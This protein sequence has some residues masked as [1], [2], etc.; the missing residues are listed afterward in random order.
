MLGITYVDMIITV[1]VLCSTEVVDSVGVLVISTVVESSAEMLVVVSTMAI[2]SVEVL[3]VIVGSVK[4]VLA[5]GLAEV[6]V[7]VVKLPPME[8]LGTFAVV[9]V[10]NSVCWSP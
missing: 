9:T 5:V 2:I 7:E 10:V 4:I 3:A 6:V 1:I 8:D